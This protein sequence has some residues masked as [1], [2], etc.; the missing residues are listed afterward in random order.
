MGFEVF[1]VLG[2]WGVSYRFF[3]YGDV[4]G[5]RGGLGEVFDSFGVIF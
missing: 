3:V 4:I 5:C 2:L 1:L